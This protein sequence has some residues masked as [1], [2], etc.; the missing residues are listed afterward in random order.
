MPSR[1]YT[2]QEVRNLV[3]DHVWVLVN[4]WDRDSRVT[5]TREKL[6]GL[7]FSMLAMLDGS[8]VGLPKFIVAPD[9]HETDQAYHTDQG[10]NF[11]QPNH[12][13]EVE[14]DISGGLH[15]EFYNRRA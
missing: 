8:S 14:C 12:E 1:V 7:A 4:H 3:L 9:P 2:E 11:F 15:E 10:S 6:Q 5:D 13:S